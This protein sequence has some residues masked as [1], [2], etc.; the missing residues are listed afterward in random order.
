MVD[1]SFAKNQKKKVQVT[2]GGRPKE[3]SYRSLCQLSR[4]PQQTYIICHSLKIY[5]IGETKPK[6]SN[7]G[8]NKSEKIKSITNEMESNRARAKTITPH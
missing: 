4:H 2:Y 6:P 5:T 7:K 3:V 1:I 8:Q